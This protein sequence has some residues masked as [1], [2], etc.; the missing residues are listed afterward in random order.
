MGAWTEKDGGIERRVKTRDFVEAYCLAGTLVPL[1]ERANHHPDLQLGWG[2]LHIRLTTHDA[3]GITDKDR[4][5]S[6][7]FDRALEALGHDAS[8]G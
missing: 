4:A 1:A 3:G 2:Y 8:G 7:Q 5:L 6:A